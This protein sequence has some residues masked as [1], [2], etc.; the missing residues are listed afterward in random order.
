MPSVKSPH[1]VRLL[2]SI[3][4]T[5]PRP[6]RLAT[7]RPFPLSANKGVLTQF[8][9]VPRLRRECRAAAAAETSSLRELSAAAGIWTAT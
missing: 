7:G 1:P 2:S 4:K 8:F 3:S 9:R 5:D 6:A